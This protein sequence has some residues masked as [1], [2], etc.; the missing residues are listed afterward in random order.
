MPGISSQL[1]SNIGPV[2][3]LSRSCGCPWKPVDA[4]EMGISLE[5]STSNIELSPDATLRALS[6]IEAAVARV[7]AVRSEVEACSLSV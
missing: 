7:V 1:A 2:S 6:T 5:S 4:I 3:T